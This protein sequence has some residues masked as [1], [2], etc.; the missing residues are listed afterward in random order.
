MMTHSV[1][2]LAQSMF[3]LKTKRARL[4]N[5]KEYLL[6]ALQIA[7][8]RREL[9][10]LLGQGSEKSNADALQYWLESQSKVDPEFSMLPLGDMEHRLRKHLERGIDKWPD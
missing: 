5:V 3:A 1:T 8:Y 6:N 9:I 7:P 2:I 4:Y 10:M